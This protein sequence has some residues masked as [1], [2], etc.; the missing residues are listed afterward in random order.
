V[1]NKI[2]IHGAR[3]HNLKNID[4]AL[5]RNKFVVITG[6][7][8]SG[9]SSLAFDTIYAEGQRRY[10]ES[11]SAYARQFL[12]Q[13]QK[14]DVEHIEG[15][16]PA[17]AIERR[18][19]GSNPR[20]TVA[21]TT[22]VYDYLR[23]LFAN[24]GEAHCHKCGR[25][26]S[27]QTVE[28]IIDRIMEFGEGTRAFILA[29][30]VRG[31][32]GEHQQ[33]LEQLRKD[34]YVRVRIDGEVKDLSEEIALNKKVKHNIEVVVDRLVIKEN[35]KSRLAD[36]VETALRLGQGIIYASTRDEE[37][38]FS[39][40]NACVH[41]GISFEKLTPRMFS[42]NSPYGACPHC[43]G[44]GV[45]ESIDPDLVVPNKSLSLRDNAVS[46]WQ[47]RGK[48]MTYHFNM[49][50][51]GLAETLDF[52]MNTPFK[53]LPEEARKAILYGSGDNMIEVKYFY[54]EKQHVQQ[55]LF[56]GVIPNLERRYRE[57][58]SMFVRKWLREFMNVIMCP[59]CGGCRLRPESAAVRVGGKNIVEIVRMT[60]KEAIDFFEGLKLSRK[61]QTIAKE[62]IKEVLARLRF[63]KNVGVEYLT[64]D[65]ASSSLSSGEAQRIR[66][67]TQIGA[68]LVGVLYILDEPTIGLHQRDNHRLLNTLYGLRD[69][70]NTV[71]VIEHDEETIRSADFV[72][73]LGPGAGVHGGE[74]IA[75]GKLKD[76]L[77]CKRSIT[78]KYLSGKCQI[79]IPK[80]RRRPNKER[81]LKIMGAREHNLKNIDVEIPLGLMC[82]ITGVS[83]SGKSTLLFEIL[84]KGLRKFLYRS[85]V[86]AGDHDTILGAEQV[87]KVIVGIE[88]ARIQAGTVQFQRER[89]PLRCLRGRW[90][91]KN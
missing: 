31:R 15:L 55:R 16:S 61:E 28:E 24:V 80:R 68:G 23:L 20:S 58:E 59:D 47:R 32:K 86:K 88:D 67:A 30:M 51:E 60:I 36:S 21:T 69:L 87:D 63:M 39:V 46:P 77:A 65:R 2:I 53:D 75:S 73:D 42:F 76:I 22:E 82:C 89:R 48:A 45:V 5:P 85:R 12:E 52:P 83:G 25:K 91:K 13:W 4:L 64:L 1:K 38:L 40:L 19:P 10:V 34:G 7:S 26:I 49:M 62:I 74:V 66:L 57:T 54:G 3:E 79:K 71:I 27:A 33:T 11:L 37:H 78:G 90:H 56:E 14:P 41:C 17:I 6:I 18:R 35:V 50:L 29:P 43:H 81:Y 44:L 72:V 70:G 8:G 9:K 84:N